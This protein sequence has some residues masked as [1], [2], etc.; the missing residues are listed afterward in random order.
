MLFLDSN[1]NIERG[2]MSGFESSVDMGE[3]HGL[4]DTHE[5]SSNWNEMGDG[6]WGKLIPEKKPKA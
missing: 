4:S 1:F 3:M 5:K 6:I 2:L